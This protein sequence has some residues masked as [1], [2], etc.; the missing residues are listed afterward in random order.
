MILKRDQEIDWQR[1]LS[2]ME[3]YWE[4]LLTALLNFRFIYPTERECIPR[5]LFDEL[6]AR[7]QAQADMPA[8]RMR[9][10]RGRLF[11]PRDYVT[12]I[13]EWGF[14]DV[15]GKGLEERHEPIE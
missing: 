9:I 14:A 2:A 3:L 7:V 11:S 1:L 10:C 6:I 13:S 12:D 15:V 5:W 8:A 4:V